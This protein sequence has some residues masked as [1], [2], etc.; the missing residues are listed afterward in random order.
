M[1]G[2]ATDKLSTRVK[3]LYGVADGGIAMVASS[4]QFFL[5]FFYTDVLHINAGIAGTALM[6]GKLTWDAVNDPVFGYVS[7]RTRTRWGRRRP[8]MLIGAI[9]LALTTWLLYSIPGELAG[10]SAFLAI[11][12]TFLLF[13]T[14]HTLVS[15]PY[16]ALT[17]EMT[18]DYDERTSLTAVRMVFSVVGYILG[19][20]GTTA[21]AGLFK[22]GL[23]W[24][25]KAAYSGMGGVFGLLAMAAVLVTTLNTRERPADDVPPSSLPPLSA[26]RQTFRNRPFMILVAAFFISSFSFTLL[27]TLLPYYLTYQMN[28]AD[29]VPL[30]LLA[31][32]GTIGLFLFPWKL[33][34]DRI[35]KGPAYALGLFI[36]CLAVITTFFLPYGPTPWIYVIAAVAGFGFSGQWVFP[37]GMLP[38]VIEY[39]QQQT[40]ERREGIYYG[41]WAFL[42]K[43]TGALGIAVAG[44]ALDAVRLC[45]QRRA[46]RDGP[47]G[48]PPLFRAGPDHRHHPEPAAVDLVSCHAGQPCPVARRAERGLGERQPRGGIAEDD[49]RP[50]V[51]VGRPHPGQG[52][53]VHLAA[54]ILVF[55]HHRQIGRDLGVPLIE[56]LERQANR[57]ARHQLFERALKNRQLF[58]G[59]LP[60]EGIAPGSFDVTDHGQHA[61]PGMAEQAARQL[62]DK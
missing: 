60:H 36:A 2:S 49:I 15:V 18:H 61:A 28:M 39:D 29:Q 16:Y 58:S 44:W 40:G 3:V 53:I 8:Y 33:V 22:S 56:I 27:T 20:G 17:P 12:V 50:R 48:H 19:A 46:D 21:I 24:S 54:A 10:V 9:P 45:A 47:A 30:V 11:L 59:V 34:A 25:D 14:M 37:W 52:Q 41:V 26:F 7:D 42:S 35:N 32:L 1:S 23:G 57:R 6:A 43:F 13:D 62:G 4:I 55:E 31:M 5:L 38:D 51:V